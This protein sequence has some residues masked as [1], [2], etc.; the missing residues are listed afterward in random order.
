MNRQNDS[1]LIRNFLEGDTKAFESIIDRYQ[2]KILNIAYRM[3]YDYEDAKDITQT[4][5]VKVFKKLNTYNPKYEFFNWIYRIAVN[6]S[7]NYLNQRKRVVTLAND[8]K[9][10]DKTPDE[11]FE[12]TELNQNI[13]HAF[14]SLKPE[15]RTIVILKHFHDLSYKEISKI[16]DIPEK[17]VKSRLFSA[18]QMLKDLL[19]QKV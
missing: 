4:V 1:E 9:S 18:R 2:K 14:M 16:L 8:Y 15:H 17:T 3:V 6:E 5:F 10:E 7:L 12:N 19:R 13:Q 11:I